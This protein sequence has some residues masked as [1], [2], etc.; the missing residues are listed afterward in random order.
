VEEVL[1]TDLPVL[2]DFRF[3][4]NDSDAQ[5]DALLEELQEEWGLRVRIGL[6]DAARYPEIAGAYHISDYSTLGMFYGG[7]IH[8]AT[9]GSGRVKKMVLF[10][11]KP[12]R[13]TP[14]RVWN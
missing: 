7:N 9:W 5:E 12:S 13:P 8:Y 3:A 2:V 4:T 1:M 10:W 14:V 11:M 6:L